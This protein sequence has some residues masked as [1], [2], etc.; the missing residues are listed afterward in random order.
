MIRFYFWLKSKDWLKDNLGRH[1]RWF[2]I[3]ILVKE[4]TKA[5]G[6]FVKVRPQLAPCQHHNEFDETSKKILLDRFFFFSNLFH[7][8]VRM[9]CNRN[10][11]WLF[12]NKH[13]LELN[14]SFTVM[15]SLLSAF[16]WFN[17]M[18]SKTWTFHLFCPRDITKWRRAVSLCLKFVINPLIMSQIWQWQQVESFGRKLYQGGIFAKQVR[19]SVKNS[20]GGNSR[21]DNCR[22]EYSVRHEPSSKCTHCLVETMKALLHRFVQVAPRIVLDSVSSRIVADLLYRTDLFGFVAQRSALESL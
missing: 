9:S 8:K 13:I 4:E 2:T 1:W 20:N 12:D 5:V 15:H 19:R 6:W 16:L 3:E 22:D 17:L 21:S 7:N 14:H 10:C 11:I 18:R